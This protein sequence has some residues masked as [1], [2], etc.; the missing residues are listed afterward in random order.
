MRQQMVS[1]VNFIELPRDRGGVDFSSAVVEG[2]SQPQKNPTLSSF[3][4][5]GRFPT[6][7]TDM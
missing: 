3:L 2:L 5:L 1:G 6:F 4:R 7:R